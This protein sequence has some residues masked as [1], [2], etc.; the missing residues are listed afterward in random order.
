MSK[1]SLDPQVERLVVRKNRVPKRRASRV[2]LVLVTVVLVGNALVGERGLVA[3]FRAK[4]ESRELSAVIG[5]IREENAWL[6]EDVRALREDPRTIEDL[7]RLELGLIRAGEQL[8][9]VRGS[10]TSLTVPAP[11]TR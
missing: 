10:P 1:P 8:F 11:A 9:I 7:A 3:M 5:E 4:L 6:R 2:V